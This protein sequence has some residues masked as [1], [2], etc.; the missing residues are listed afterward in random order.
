ML[1]GINCTYDKRQERN[2]GPSML[3]KIEEKKSVLD[4]VS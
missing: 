4:L 1:E 2:S 3:A